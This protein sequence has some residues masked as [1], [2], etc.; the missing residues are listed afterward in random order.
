MTNVAINFQPQ[1]DLEYLLDNTPI[2]ETNR[3][4]KVI[5]DEEARVL[6]YNTEDNKVNIYVVTGGQKGDEAK[7]KVTSLIRSLD[8]RIGWAS[9]DSSTHNAG[10]GVYTLDKTG[11]LVRVSLHISPETI[12]DPRFKNFIGQNV[13]VNPFSTEQE[14]LEFRKKT[15]RKELGTDYHLMI[16]SKANLVIPTNR[17]DDVVGKKNAMGSTVSGATSSCMYAAGKRAPTLEDALYCPERFVGLVQHQIREFEDRLSHDEEFISLGITDS[18]SLG[19]ILKDDSTKGQNAR[20]DALRKK[21]S[22]EE[23]EFFCSDNAAQFLL[24][25]YQRILKSGLFEIGDT[26]KERN[27]LIENGVAGIIEGT[28]STLLSGPEK[29]DVDRTSAPTSSMGLIGLAGLT[30]PNI[31]YKRVSAFKYC[32]TSVGGNTPTMS[33]F[34]SQDRLSELKATLPNGEKISFELTSTVERFMNKET[35]KK[36]FREVDTAFYT[37]IESGDSLNY[38]TVNIEGVDCQFTL[39][40]ARAILAAYV[41][42]E[43]GETSKR[44]R[45]CRLDDKI[46]TNRV[47]QIE[48]ETLQ[49][50]NAVDR[51]LF[52]N[53]VG[54]ITGYK[55][56]K[57]GY[58]NYEVGEVINPG[59]PLLMEC[60]TIKYCIP[61]VKIMPSW[62]SLCVDGNGPI[63]GQE[64]NPNLS[65]YLDYVSDGRTIVAIGTGP[66]T[67]DIVSIKEI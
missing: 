59:D 57:P 25:G 19:Q 49:V 13:Q 33:G 51:A 2:P 52:S 42:G 62:D 30:H 45:T 12:V 18:K 64:L 4:F 31:C 3:R 24:E 41:Y 22:I 63:T 56:T 34:I 48:G 8:P 21:L 66:K 1:Q 7:A 9:T 20:L 16:D 5:S 15:G 58:R 36:L 39:A 32:N 37:A 26:R 28:Q 67:K 40:E 27:N 53:Q 55:V 23:I 10:K 65:H 60:E 61:I 11:N 14:L 35:A 44:S 47:Y 6:Y 43:T 38:S 46:E 17:A 50:R 29:Y 54:V